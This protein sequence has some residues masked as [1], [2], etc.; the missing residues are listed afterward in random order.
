VLR[1]TLQGMSQPLMY[2]LL[3]HEVAGSRHGAS[4]GLRNVVVRLG[5]IIV[6]AVMGVVADAYG[7]EAS[8][9]VVGA[10]LLLATA[11]LAVVARNL[12]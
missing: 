11:G 4:V 12:R 1:G 10:V 3:S 6:P 8:F 2:G 9:Y 5:G 7:V